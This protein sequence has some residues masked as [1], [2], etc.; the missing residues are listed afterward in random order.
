MEGASTEVCNGL[1]DDCNGII[2]DGLDAMMTII[3]GSQTV[4]YSDK[5][6]TITLTVTNI[7]AD[8]VN[9]TLTLEW[10]VNSGAFT[11]SLPMNLVIKP[12]DLDP[13]VIDTGATCVV[14][15]TNPLLYWD[16]SWNIS[17][18][19]GVPAGIYTLKATLSE[20]DGG[21][22]NTSATITVLPENA[23]CKFDADNPVSVRVES[24]GED[25][26]D[27]SLFVDVKEKQPDL[28]ADYNLPGE[29]GLAQVDMSL[30]HVGSGGSIPA[31][32]C[33]NVT[34]PDGYNAIKTFECYFDNV[35][36]DAYTIAV[37]IDGD[38]YYAG[39]C[40]DVL[41]VYDPSLGFTTGGGKFL[42]D[43]DETNFGYTMKYNKKAT[44]IQGN[45]LLIRHHLE[46]EIETIYRVKS[47]AL[48]GLALG[49]DTSVPMGWAS[50]SGK[51]TYLE[52]G[53]SE[54]EGNYE[55]IVY[56]EDRN[57]PGTGVDRFWIQINGG[58]SISMPAELN[59]IELIGGN[60]VV[61]HKAASKDEPKNTKNK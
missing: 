56:V 47:N 20:N 10:N 8:F 5:I 7:P 21:T 52:P 35:P 4:Q 39:S 38:S 29:I 40:E 17:G 46:D 59:A 6:D 51:S 58:E 30:V 16:C 31:D 44:N 11:S 2:D 42:W 12:D 27:F 53:M 54:P 1:D 41:V 3:N 26:G 45:L 14:N 25:S 34:V 37:T 36:V 43:G 32:E 9:A 33:T 55:F 61:P 19:L 13:E 60:I 50:F 28:P 15:E 57:E 23:S 49:E 22:P 18:S 24:D 48:Y